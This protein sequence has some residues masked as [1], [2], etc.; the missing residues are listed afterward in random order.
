MPDLRFPPI[1]LWFG[2]GGFF[3][4]LLGI[5][6][7][8]E[9]MVRKPKAGAKV[10]LRATQIIAGLL[11]L[12]SSILFDPQTAFV[13]L[14][15]QLLTGA[16][17]ALALAAISFR[18]KMLDA[19]GAIAAFILGTVIFGLGGWPFSVPLLAFFVISNLLSKI[20]NSKKRRASEGF[21]KGSCR[22]AG[23]VLANGG[24]A[25]VLVILWTLDPDPIWYYFYLGAV[26]AVTADT[27]AT[28]LGLFSQAT[29]RLIT[30]MRPVAAG[31]SGAVSTLG[32]LGAAAGAAV[33]AV[34]AW[35]IPLTQSTIEFRIKGSG[36]IVVG[37]ILASLFD[38][39]LGATVQ[40]QRICLVC[41]E[42]SEKE[43]VCC[44][45]TMKTSSGWPWVDNDVVN[46]ACAVC[47]GLLAAL[48]M[49]LIQ[50]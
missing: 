17:L 8:S 21:Q 45:S 32:M 6:A 49:G 3:P 43:G 7:T 41:H 50:Q 37:G 2:L 33:I 44:G 30:T 48:G 34:L 47:G 1:D 20:H 28:E 18:F 5:A 38:S 4:L 31:T 36:V 24:V 35:I 10:S 23:Q 27:W 9:W 22:D 11:A 13:L 40:A 46:G 29:P 39:F 42:K 25:G 14:S 12:V 16:L 19:S 26:A 15:D